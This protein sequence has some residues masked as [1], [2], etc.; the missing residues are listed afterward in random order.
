MATRFSELLER[1]H[2]DPIYLRQGSR[3]VA[4]LELETTDQPWAIYFITPIDK[5]AFDTIAPPFIST[6]PGRGG[7]EDP[8][9]IRKKL[10]KKLFSR[11]QAIEKSDLWLATEDS[12]LAVGD[13][14]MHF[15]DQRAHIRAHE[16][17]V[18]PVWI[19]PLLETSPP[20]D[21]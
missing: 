8:S 5:N 14:M 20:V 9:E 2:R 12:S 1:S 4:R 19:R 10:A 16:R 6:T 3:K 13:F 17:G 21:G 11:V 7:R 18:V 15:L